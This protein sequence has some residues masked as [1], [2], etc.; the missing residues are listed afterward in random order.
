MRRRQRGRVWT[1]WRR[2]RRCAGTS[3][4]WRRAAIA[5]AIMP[6]AV[7]CRDLVGCSRR[8]VDATARAATRRHGCLDEHG[9]PTVR[10]RC[11]LLMPWCM[12]RVVGARPPAVA[13][14]RSPQRS[15]STV[16][17][18][19]RSGC[20][21]DDEA[22]VGD[23]PSRGRLARKVLRGVKRVSVVPLAR[24]HGRGSP[25]HGTDSTR[26]RGAGRNRPSGAAI[27]DGRQHVA[28]PRLMKPSSH[29]S[30]P[31]DTPA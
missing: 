4:S 9:A 11:D 21:D 10:S 22:G 26:S 28:I 27:V 7:G 24:G 30:C 31:C 19:S 18:R 14:G 20:F 8:G 15:I 5:G 17:L 29:R 2:H 23:G 3:S 25:S 1:R 13:G 16:E 12:Q 6:R